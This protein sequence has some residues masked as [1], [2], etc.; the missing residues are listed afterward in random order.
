MTAAA[1]RRK[2]GA[3]VLCCGGY[4]AQGAKACSNHFLPYAQLY[5]LVR[6]ELRSLLCLS[7]TERQTTL[8]AA[9]RELGPRLRTEEQRLDALLREKQQ[10]LRDLCSLIR[11]AFEQFARGLQSEQTCALLVRGYE[12]E[13]TALEKSIAELRER[14]SATCGERDLCGELAA[15]LGRIEA[16]EP[17]RPD[18]L[19]RFID[20]IEV[21]QGRSGDGADGAPIRRQSV[22]IVYRFRDPENKTP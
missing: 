3:P 4:K 16:L 22:R 20:R 5:E 8:L 21:G 14:F 18:L 6:D 1:P 10:R 9:E 19:R 11:G 12:E 7:D 15:E 17:L 2:D 13:R